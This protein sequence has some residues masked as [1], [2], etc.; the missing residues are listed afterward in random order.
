MPAEKQPKIVVL[1]T[2]CRT[3]VA[4]MVW[5]YLHYLLGFEQLGFETYYVECHGNWFSNPVDASDGL[6]DQR[7]L[8]G[9]VMRQYGFGDRWMCRADH[10]APGHT[11]GGLSHEN[12]LTVYAEAEA[13]INVTGSHFIDDDQL[14][15]PRRVYLE[16]DPGIPQIRLHNG[17]SKMRELVQAHTHHF[18]WAQNLPNP[19]C[20]LPR[21]DLHLEPTRQPIVVDLWESAV[22]LHCQSFTTVA[23]WIKAKSKS[24]EFCGET[25]R[26]NKDV[27]FLKFLD[28][29]QNTTQSLE[30]ALSMINR[31]DQAMLEQHGWS[32][33]DALSVSTSLD[34]YRRYIQRSRGEFTIAKDQYVRLATGWFSDRSACYL[35]AGKPVITQDTGFSNVL[36]TG[37]GL[38]AFQTLEDVLAAFDAINS[39]YHKHCRA[40]LEIAHEYFDSKKVLGNLLR[41]IGIELDTKVGWTR[42]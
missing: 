17:D 24:I 23:R 11:F 31:E 12:L 3:P 4:G 19:D 16:T 27:E 28:L 36:P 18:T 21:N 40:A 10:V 38:F 34:D 30:L 9:D 5:L 1:G 42:D 15:C 7:V 32:V 37:E 8:I 25:Y 39:N 26:W 35:A 2:M 22:N 13:I 6:T 41:Q 29:P 14:Q 33:I 20:L